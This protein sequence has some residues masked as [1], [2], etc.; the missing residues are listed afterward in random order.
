MT[1]NSFSFW[2]G[3]A[4]SCRSELTTNGYSA[5]EL[6]LVSSARYVR[7]LNPSR[8][9]QCVMV[10][11]RFWMRESWRTAI[12]GGAVAFLILYGGIQQGLGFV[13]FEGLVARWLQI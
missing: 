12:I 5:L 3:Y 9:R 4:A 6:K 1:R 13:L 11:Q 2:V 7:S 8:I 10:S